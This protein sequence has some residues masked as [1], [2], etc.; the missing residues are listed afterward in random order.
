MTR[1]GNA[2]HEELDARGPVGV[3]ASWA[4]TGATADGAD[5]A[6][7]DRVDTVRTF[8]TRV[9]KYTDPPKAECSPKASSLMRRERLPRPMHKRPITGV[10][11]QHELTGA[12]L[13][14]LPRKYI[15]M[16]FGYVVLRLG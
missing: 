11:R 1:V 2:V 16:R 14:T 13:L 9:Y 5:M 12:L 6:R 10:A 3:A 8:L 7:T 15:G 4:P